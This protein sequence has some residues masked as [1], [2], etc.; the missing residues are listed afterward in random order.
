MLAR[1]QESGKMKS[2]E[3]RSLPMVGRLAGLEWSD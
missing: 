1:R 3:A 2:I